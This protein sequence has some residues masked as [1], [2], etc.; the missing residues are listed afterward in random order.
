MNILE[1]IEQMKVGKLVRHKDYIYFGQR[2]PLKFE[3]RMFSLPLADE[4]PEDKYVM[5]AHIDFEDI[6][7][8]G[9][10]MYE[11]PNT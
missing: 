2:T 6:L 11:L 7:N 10:E 9:W 5:T 4:K 3:Y 8:D 1:A